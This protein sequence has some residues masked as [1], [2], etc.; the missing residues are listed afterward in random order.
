MYRMD[1]ML[2]ALNET[3]PK[4]G[5]LDIGASGFR[6][7]HSG[8]YDELWIANEGHSQP[9]LARVR[10]RSDEGSG[11]GLLHQHELMQKLPAGI[12]PRS[13]HV[14]CSCEV[15]RF[16]FRVEEFVVG[17]QPQKPDDE[18]IVSVAAMMAR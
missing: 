2:C 14:D 8:T 7:Y 5:L 6:H 11:G 13:L 9:L 15:V 12:G 4:R 3:V 16:P 1:D 10:V 18:V 17:V